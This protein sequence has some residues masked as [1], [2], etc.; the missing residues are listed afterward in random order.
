MLRAVEDRLLAVSCPKINLQIRRT[1][2]D[3]VAFYEAV[4]YI[5]DDV[6]SMGKRIIH[7]TTPPDRAR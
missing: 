1:N 2:L 3:A 4:G 6:I 7:G 5:E